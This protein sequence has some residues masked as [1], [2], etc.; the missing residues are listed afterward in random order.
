MPPLTG[1]RVLDCSMAMPG[2]FCTCLLADLGADVVKVE[3]PGGDLL[4]QIGPLFDS[5]NRSKRS[6]VLNLKAAEGQAIARRLAAGADLVVEQFRPG[7]AERIGIGYT[8][9]SAVNPARVYCSISGFGQTG[10][11]RLWAG[12]DL[13]YL[14]MG[15]Y[16]GLM[17]G[18]G[19][20]APPPVLVSDLV[21]GLYAAVAL[22]AALEERRRTG[23]GQY[24]DLAMTDSVVALVAGE[25]NQYHVSGRVAERPNV[26]FLPH[27]DTF[28]TADGGYISVGVVYEPH[29]WERLCRLTGLE[30]LIG[31]DLAARAADCAGVHERL[32][33][34]F[35]ERP[36]DEWERLLQAQ[37]IPSAGVATLAEVLDNPQ[38]RQRGLFHTVIDAAGRGSLQ[39]GPPVHFS[40]GERQAPTPPPAPGQHTGEILA[41]LGYSAG[42]VAA[43]AEA[44]VVQVA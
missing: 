29:F 2:P 40:G 39:V 33:A 20:P 15:G 9:L 25:L 32:A 22:L 28:A 38:F 41:D 30:D 18:P 37:D 11:G 16:L 7:V 24:I 19:R 5:V 17:L 14:A 12:H 31:L 34:A 6:L 3:P 21:S 44:G 42:E 10:P 35:R 1:V 8:A 26:S 27:Y 13:N 36:R 4:R 43:L 23:R